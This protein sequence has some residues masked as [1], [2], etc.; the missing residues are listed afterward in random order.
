[1]TGVDIL[2]GTKIS[3]LDELPNNYNQQDYCKESELGIYKMNKLT[4][5]QY[6]Y[7]MNAFRTFEKKEKKA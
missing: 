4:N 3:E 6:F 1:L 5:N 2:K 7:V